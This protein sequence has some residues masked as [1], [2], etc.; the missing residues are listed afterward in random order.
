MSYVGYLVR[1]DEGDYNIVIPFRSKASAEDAT[2]HLE[3]L[4]WAEVKGPTVSYDTPENWQTEANERLH[5]RQQAN[6]P[7]SE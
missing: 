6:R 7:W 1:D 2:K 4:L 3:L 5:A